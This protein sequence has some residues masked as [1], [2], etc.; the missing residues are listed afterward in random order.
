MSNDISNITRLAPVISADAVI[1]RTSQKGEKAALTLN[2]VKT[3]TAS[4]LS[5]SLQNKRAE[6][7]TADVSPEELKSA[8]NQGNAI[9][10]AV[11]RNLQIEVDDSTKKVIVKVVDQ[12]TGDVVRQMPS[13]EVLSFLKQMQ[14]Q[15]GGRGSFIKSRA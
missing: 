1:T 4:A 8:V 12:A 6:E 14:E 5:L 7:K 2:T 13:K 9:F 11:Q 3:A 10:Q 15:E